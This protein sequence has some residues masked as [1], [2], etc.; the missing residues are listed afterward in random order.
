MI[1]RA[2]LFPAALGV[3]LLAATSAP[4]A[5][6]SE[7]SE[8]GGPEEMAREGIERLM[9]ALEAFLS[10]IPQYGVPYVDDDGDIVIPRL[11]QPDDEETPKQDP[12]APSGQTEI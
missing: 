6:S 4:L 2:Y 1:R 5:Q 12:N 7:E 3:M 10:S 9:N 8:Q 11:N